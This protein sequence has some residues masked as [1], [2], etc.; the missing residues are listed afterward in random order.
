MDPV[1]VSIMYTSTEP[2][3]GKQTLG[4]NMRNINMTP[5]NPNAA[6]LEEGNRG[7][8]AKFHLK[9]DCTHTSDTIRGVKLSDYKRF[10]AGIISEPLKTQLRHVASK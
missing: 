6:S 10:F 8:G 3:E 2:L 9:V 4:I 5:G 7:N 1:V